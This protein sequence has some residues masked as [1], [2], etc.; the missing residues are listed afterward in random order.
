M[1][2]EKNNNRIIKR[3]VRW[4]WVLFLVLIVSG[5]FFIFTIRINLWNL[6]GD[7]PSYRSL[8]NPRSELSSLLFSSDNV[9]LGS[10]YRKNRDQIEYKDL[11]PGSVLEYHII[12][13]LFLEKNIHEYHSCGHTYDYLLNWTDK[14]RDYI[15]Y[16]IFKDSFYMHLQYLFE[17]KLLMK[18][19][20][21]PCYEKVKKIFFAVRI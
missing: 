17:Y 7:F 5:V 10:Y 11:S 14:T 21:I 1:S 16:E 20:K 13:R 2:S 4:I 3:L 19:R 6:Y 9:L 15:N 12:S 18:L 8:E